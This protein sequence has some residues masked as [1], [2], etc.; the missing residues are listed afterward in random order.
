MTPLPQLSSILYCRQKKELFLV[1][2]VSQK[3]A[4]TEISYLRVLSLYNVPVNIKVA[5]QDIE[6]NKP[7]ENCC[8]KLLG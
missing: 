4:Y 2:V 6:N 3:N 1:K 7:I 5:F 8:P